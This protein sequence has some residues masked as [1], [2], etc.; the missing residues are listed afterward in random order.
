MERESPEDREEMEAV[1][2]QPRSVDQHFHSMVCPRERVFIRYSLAS[3]MVPY[4]RI[5][6]NARDHVVRKKMC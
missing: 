2:E 6:P 5:H 1:N 3:M 4:V